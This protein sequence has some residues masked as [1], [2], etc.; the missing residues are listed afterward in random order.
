[1]QI[2]KSFVATLFAVSFIWNP[3]NS[4][5]QEQPQGK[6]AIVIHGGA[7]GDPAKWTD[8]YKATRRDGL[9]RALNLGVNLLK[10]DATALDVVEQVVRAL[11]D[12]PIFNAGRGCVLNKMGEHELDASIMDGSNRACGAVA[13]TRSTKNPVSLA[14]RVMTDTEHVLLIGTGADEFGRSL[15]LEQADASYFRTAEQVKAWE[16]WKNRDPDVTLH[17]P[18]G[19]AEDDE[20][21]YLGTVGCA[22][23]DTRGNL[24]AA[25]ST[26]GLMGKRW[27][28]VGDSPI[29]GAGTF[30]DNGT[31][32]VSCTGVGEDFIR[33]NV[34]ADIAARMRYGSH[35][36]AEATQA[37]VRTVLPDDC[38]GIIA[39]DREGNIVMEFNTPGMSRGSANSAGRNEVRLGKD[40]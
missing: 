14:R 5:A 29:I 28:R 9:Q 8:D 34:A 31:C 40:N 37:V 3:M 25:T 4:N 35:S 15:G 19:Q 12:D 7:G 23:L 17:R 36:L 20:Q 10:S 1:M 6:F 30:A 38:G 11:E 21:L 2:I 33:N 13:S 22:A 27:G 39:V 24:A 16:R 18:K 32:A 26:G